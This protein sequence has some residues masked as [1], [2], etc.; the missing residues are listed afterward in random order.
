VPRARLTTK[1]LAQRIDLNYFKRPHPLR[2]W[3]T[4]LSVFVPAL[5]LVFVAWA[6]LRGNDR[7]YSSGKMSAGHAVL[8]ARCSECHVKEAG[9][10]SSKASDNACRACHDGPIHHANQVFT[11]NCSSCHI[12]HRGHRRLAATVDSDCTQCHANLRTTGAPSQFF[13]QIDGFGSSHPEFAPLRGGSVDPGTIKLN[14]AVHLKANLLGPKGPVQLDCDDCHRPPTSNAPWRF[15]SGQLTVAAG[16]ATP[17]GPAG[18]PMPLPRKF[19]PPS[20]VLARAY[21]APSTY[22][23]TCI[24]CHPLQFDKR[25]PQSVPHDTPEVVHAF[26][27]QKFQ[28]YIPAHPEELRVAGPGRNL[29]QQPLAPVVRVL[30]PQQWVAERVAESEELLWRKTCLQCHSLVFSVG[31]ALPAVAKSNITPRWFSHAVFDHEEHRFVKCLECHPR[32]AKSQETADILLPGI[33][34]CQECHHSGEESAES[35]CFE[36]HIYHDWSKEKPV[37]GNL[38]IS[39]SLRRD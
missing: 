32:A 33:R 26:V 4:V 7:V 30:T 1:K 13:L 16:A 17:A 36:C 22:A 34:T 19:Y 10:F 23:N 12:E 21:M 20:Q 31:A 35:R 9:V 24:G 2:R 29:P 39:Q 14:H 27:V 11:P 15:G 5:A 38:T 6:A 8:T 25:F 18:N 37:K 28:Q 3:R